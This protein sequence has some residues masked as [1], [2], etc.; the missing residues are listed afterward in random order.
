[1][2]A[3][4]D[5]AEFFGLLLKTVFAVLVAIYRCIIPVPLKSVREKVILVTGAGSGLGRLLAQKFALLGARV[6]LVDVDETRNND[7]LQTLKQMQC[8]AHAYTCDISNENQVEE[9]GDKVTRDVGSVDILI[10]NAGV[11]SAKPLME[12]S[13]EQIKRTL[14]I[15]T[16]SHFWTIRQFLPRMLENGEGHIVA[17]ASA[18]GMIGCSNLVDYCASK[19]AVMGLMSALR[20]ELSDTGKEDFIQ[21]T[22][23]CPGTMNTGMVESPKTRFPSILPI[24]NVEDVSDKVVKAVL[25]NKRILVIPTIVHVIYKVANLFPLEVPMD[26]Q[27]YLGYSIDP[28]KK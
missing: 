28:N 6:V 18:A 8:K 5:I 2:A 14:Q 27:R 23:I 26:L 19:H 16:L 24:L 20:E 13:N 9:L 12:L 22:V 17:I 7:T 25:Q 11:M 10:N 1:M 3:L 21:L 15:N 4:E